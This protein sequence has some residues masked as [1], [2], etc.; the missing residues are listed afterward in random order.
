MLTTK[1][2]FPVSDFARFLNCGPTVLAV[3]QYNGPPNIITLAWVTP[4]SHRPPLIVAS[5]SPRRF[6]HDLI[7]NAGELT[8]NIPP[9]ERLAEVAFCGR[10]SGRNADKFAEC[11]FTP[12]PSVT[13]APPGIGE[14][15]VTLECAVQDH[16]PVGDHTLFTLLVRRLVADPTAAEER[17]G[18][19]AGLPTTIH[20][21]GGN[22]YAPLGGPSREPEAQK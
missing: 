10:V 13:I 2:D 4:V 21:L 22:L 18:L 5:V 1:V 15:L 9:W 8:L 17:F 7:V 20:H 19:G 14:C 6:S 11:A 12:V 3:A 16:R